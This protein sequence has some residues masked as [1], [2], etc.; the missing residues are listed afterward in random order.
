MLENRL[1]VARHKW[2]RNVSI[3]R[4]HKEVYFFFLSDGIVP[5]AD[6]CVG[7]INLHVHYNS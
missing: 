3:R 6:Y 7:Y 1:V 4:K 5:Y 2:V